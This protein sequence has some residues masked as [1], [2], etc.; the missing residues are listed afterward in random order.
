M[1]MCL[2]VCM[3]LSS[4]YSS[5]NNSVRI[6]AFHASLKVASGFE[7]VFLNYIVFNVF[8]GLNARHW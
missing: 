2:F 4:V 5:G 6:G 1:R 3:A 7:T 8:I